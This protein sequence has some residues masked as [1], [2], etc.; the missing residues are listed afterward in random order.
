MIMGYGLAGSTPGTSV[1]DVVGSDLM[2]FY[3]QY[4]FCC[5]HGEEDYNEEQED[6]GAHFFLYAFSSKARIRSNIRAL[7]E[8][9]FQNLIPRLTDA[10]T[11]IS[12]SKLAA[13]RRHCIGATD[14]TSPFVRRQQ[15]ITVIVSVSVIVV[16]DF[17]SRSATPAIPRRVYDWGAEMRDDKHRISLA[18]A[19]RVLRQRVKREALL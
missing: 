2:A 13:L 11:P 17:V 10:A 12:D 15:Q 14:S 5:G 1:D 16:V 3:R 4:G 19:R 8:D 18:A 6:D 9:F 7:L